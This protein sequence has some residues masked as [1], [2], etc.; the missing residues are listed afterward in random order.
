MSQAAEAGCSSAS[1]PQ[2]SG[3]DLG[4][5]PSVRYHV[6][7]LALCA[8]ALMAAA[9]LSVRGGSQVVLPLV[10]VPLPEL[11]TM[12]RVTGIDCPGCGMTRCFISLAHGDVASAWSFNPAGLWFFGIA[13][14]QIP[15]RSLQ[16][17]RISRG[18]PEI[19]SNRATQFVLIAC[20]VAILLQWG[21]RLAGMRF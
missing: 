13:A 18:M 4:N 10:N 9:L 20:V 7:W 5:W 21:L 6:I 14:L 3:S 15:F 16:L 19:R 11:C 12:R 1:L 17:W 2:A 8:G